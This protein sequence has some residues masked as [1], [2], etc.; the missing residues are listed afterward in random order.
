MRLAKHVCNTIILERNFNAVKVKKNKIL[1][2]RKTCQTLYLPSANVYLLYH[3]GPYACHIFSSCVSL[4]I[5]N[6][7]IAASA[8]K[9]RLRLL[10]TY[11]FQRY[12]RNAHNS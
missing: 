5:T 7:Q 8:V 6:M 9:L 3:F 4:D 10:A 2:Y 11:T 1:S 12:S